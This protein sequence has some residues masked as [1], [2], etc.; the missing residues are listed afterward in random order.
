MPSIEPTNP[1]PWCGLII[2]GQFFGPMGSVFVLVKGQKCPQDDLDA[3]RIERRGKAGIGLN[4][5]AYGKI[6][7]RMIGEKN[8]NGQWD[9]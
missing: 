9:W 8:R 7:C 4:R 1:H 2:R 3:S 5:P 6:I